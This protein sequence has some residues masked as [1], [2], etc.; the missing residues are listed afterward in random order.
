MDART[1]RIAENLEVLE[2]RW[3]GLILLGLMDGELRFR[4]LLGRVEGI[5]D[6]MLVKRLRELEAEELVTKERREA[7]VWYALTKKA[8][9]AGPVLD[10]LAKWRRR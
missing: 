2:S 6:A 3:N 1:E 4:A 7:E 8:T 10:A 5:T 9:G